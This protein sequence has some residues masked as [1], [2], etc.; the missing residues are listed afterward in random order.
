MTLRVMSAMLIIKHFSDF[1]VQM[2]A[3]MRQVAVKGFKPQ[4]LRV[5]GVKR[6]EGH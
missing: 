3:T 4:E 5:N 2:A 6:H 1:T